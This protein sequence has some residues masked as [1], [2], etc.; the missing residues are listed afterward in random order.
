[1]ILRIERECPVA[2]RSKTPRGIDLSCSLHCLL[3]LRLGGVKMPGDCHCSHNSV[4]ILIPTKMARLPWRDDDR[5][6]I[7]CKVPG[8]EMHRYS[9]SE[10]FVMELKRIFGYRR[11]LDG[12]QLC[13]HTFI[14]MMYSSLFSHM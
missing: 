2:L 13:T 5:R 6:R 7:R 10:R 8:R 14:V 1:M 4:I 9:V 12:F 11:I 3:S